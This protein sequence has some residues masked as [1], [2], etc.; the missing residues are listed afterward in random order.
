MEDYK[1][2]SIVKGEV[3][4]IESYGIFLKI[5]DTNGLIHISEI[6]NNYISNINKYVNIGEKIYAEIIDI[7][8]ENNRLKL[9][10][11]GLNYK[12]FYS[13]RKVQESV[14]G[15]S[16][17]QQNLEKWMDETLKEMEH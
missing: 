7:D 6:A 16:P 9:S 3:T 11:K 12:E 15:F 2:G 10:I 13:N 1:V 17:L 5:G 14:R 4:G 8:T